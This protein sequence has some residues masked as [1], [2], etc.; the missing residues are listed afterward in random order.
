MTYTRSN[1]FTHSLSE[2][3][4]LRFE[5]KCVIQATL[6]NPFI[7]RMIL[8]FDEATLSS[9]ERMSSQTA[10]G[11]VIRIRMFQLKYGTS[12]HLKKK[13]GVELTKTK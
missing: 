9:N 13:F 5:F 12:N 6:D 2:D 8:F 10:G 11:E 7:A 4:D 3:Y 1:Y